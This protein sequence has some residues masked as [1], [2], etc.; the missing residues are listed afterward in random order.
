MSQMAV[1]I[2]F[3][4]LLSYCIQNLF[5]QLSLAGHLS[6]FQV[7]TNTTINMKTL[8]YFEN[9]VF[10]PCQGC[11][12]ALPLLSKPSP[13]CWAPI[14]CVSLDTPISHPVDVHTGM[15]S[16]GNSGPDFPFLRP[17]HTAFHN[18]LTDLHSRQLP[19]SFLLL[20]VSVLFQH[21][22]PFVLVLSIEN[23]VFFLAC[24]ADA[25]EVN[26]P[27]REPS[28]S[29]V[30]LYISLYTNPTLPWSL[31]FSKQGPR[32]P[33]PSSSYRGSQIHAP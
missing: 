20:S 31:R 1:P 4:Q 9:I 21:R 32:Q 16:L 11:S 25:S 28:V 10:L 33:L 14:L 22:C 3:T 27:Q 8:L 30:Y 23:T 24:P 29:S 18:G 19:A 2:L 15:W 26:W 7:L 17:L 5:C 12:S 13:L 6:W